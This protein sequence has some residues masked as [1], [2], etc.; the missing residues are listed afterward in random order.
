MLEKDKSLKDKCGVFGVYG[1]P[2]A[3]QF[4]YLGLYAL[5]HRGAES[6]GIITSDGD[7]FYTH[8][9]MGEV[10]TV[11]TSPQI[12]ESLKGN[13]ALGHNRYS[14][15]GSSDE[16]N[17]QPIL[18]TYWGGE[19][20]I[21]HNG[22]LVN[23]NQLRKKLE[24]GGAVF[25]T[26]TD[27]EVFIHLLAKCKKTDLPERLATALKHVKGAYSLGLITKDMLIAARDPH[28]FRPLCLGKL[29]GG[30]VIASESCALDIMKAE[31]IRDIEPG[32][33]LIIDKNGPRTASKMAV[34]QHAHCIF[35]FVYF[36][37]PD[38]MIFGENV[39]KV[40]RKLG[41][42]LAWESPVDADVVIA[43][44]DSSNTAALGYSEASG[45]RMEIGLIRNHY[46]GRTFILPSQ[47]IRDIDALIKYNPVKGVIQGK[48]VV[49]VDDSIVRGTTSRKIISMLKDAGPDKLHYRVSSPPI[50]SPCYYGIDI[51]TSE[52]LIAHKHSIKEIKHKIGV[53]S[54]AY[55]SIDG[56]LSTTKRQPNEFCTACFSK[57]YPVPVSNCNAYRYGQ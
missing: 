46:I 54:L 40:R 4:S 41:R 20:G 42:R 39:D 2:H 37:R 10:S 55:L 44:P 47:K 7:N 38:S 29:D 19:I 14:T 48:R 56:M 32:E 43:V 28:G 31:Y 17:I 26:M 9:G 36:S 52:E 8:R 1:I 34:K 27:T 25:R 18:T 33:I 3:A 35:E 6:A 30:F 11:F 15:T 22:N 16:A 53:D 45:I 12:I 13:I 49:V 51:P 24:S 5:Q 50:V 57:K 23:Y 21:A